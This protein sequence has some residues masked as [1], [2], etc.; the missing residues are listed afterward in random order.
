MKKSISLIL[1]I[2]LVFS[3]STIVSAEIGLGAGEYNGEVT[4]TYIAGVE[5][6]GKVFCVDITWENLEFTYHAANEPVWDTTNHKYTDSSAAYWDGM[7]TITVTN[8][9]NV[10][11]SAVPEFVA[12]SGFENTELS[13]S[14]SK[15][16]LPSSEFMEFGTAHT[17]AILVTAGGTLPAETNGKIGNVK[18][19]IAEDTD[20]TVVDANALYEIAE[21]LAM[22]ADLYVAHEMEWSETEAQ[23][24][25]IF[26]S[27]IAT[28]NSFA[29][30]LKDAIST[31]ETASEE[32]QESLNK[33]YVNTRNY[34][35]IVL[36]KLNAYRATDSAAD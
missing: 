23:E 19:T 9:S 21:N 17:G 34:Y 27:D 3:M 7:G 25:S 35:N 4:G 15:L 36:G 11:I 16:H 24:V 29:L 31:Y 6:S 10:I 22:E 8:H 18:V 30:D 12:D 1:A 26:Q 14:T 28:L 33:A 32:K 5:G 13:F 20:V 2:I